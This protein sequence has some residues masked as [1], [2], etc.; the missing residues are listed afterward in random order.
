MLAFSTL[1]E[2]RES[3]IEATKFLLVAII[4]QVPSNLLSMFFL[5]IPVT[6]IF[7]RAERYA[8]P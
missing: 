4:E 3:L 2:C 1:Q 7:F 6:L 8:Y 5:L